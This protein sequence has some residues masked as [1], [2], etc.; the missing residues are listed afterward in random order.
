MIAP[1]L[2]IER[3]DQIP[4]AI[5]QIQAAGQ[6]HRAVPLQALYRGLISHVEVQRNTPARHVKTF[7]ASARR[8]ELVLIGDDDEAPTGPS[9]WGQAGRLLKWARYILIHAAGGRVEEYQE[10]VAVALIT[11][12]FLLIETSSAFSE[13]WRAVAIAAQPNVRIGMILARNGKHPM[14]VTRGQMQ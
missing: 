11:G 3:W 2:R 1:A 9:G 14:P 7:I 4:Q 12:R 6:H 8:P 13:A 10:A 5:S